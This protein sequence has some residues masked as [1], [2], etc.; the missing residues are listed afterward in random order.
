[1][2]TTKTKSEKEKKAPTKVGSSSNLKAKSKSDKRSREEKKEHD[3]PSSISDSPL[4]EI[5]IDGLPTSLVQSKE[6]QSGKP[7][8]E[9]QISRSLNRHMYTR[10]VSSLIQTNEELNQLRS[11]LESLNQSL[12]S[13]QSQLEES[14]QGKLNGEALLAKLNVDLKGANILLQTLQKESQNQVQIRDKVI[15]DSNSVFTRHQKK[16]KAY[17]NQKGQ[18]ES[19]N[20]ELKKE[21]QVLKKKKKQK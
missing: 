20:S 16:I 13:K 11:K 21:L 15:V 5:L 18:L 4:R 7:P 17:K 9:R 12:D 2:A 10:S 8:L 1:V 3:D 19:E 14:R 6:K